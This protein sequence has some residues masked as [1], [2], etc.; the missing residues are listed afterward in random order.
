MFSP[1]FI[2]GCILT[3]DNSSI[4]PSSHKYLNIALNLCLKCLTINVLTYCFIQTYTRSVRCVPYGYSYMS[5]VGKQMTE[6]YIYRF[7]IYFQVFNFMKNDTI[8][9]I[10][11][12]AMYYLLHATIHTIFLPT[13]LSSTIT[14][15]NIPIHKK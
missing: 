10:L 15:H 6:G 7:D 5:P 13:F 14:Q 2:E 12:L 3:I 9:E 4:C 1:Y 8:W 11:H